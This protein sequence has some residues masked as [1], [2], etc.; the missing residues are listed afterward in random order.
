MVEKEIMTRRV[1]RKKDDERREGDIEEED[2]I[3]G[4]EWR[5]RTYM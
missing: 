4:R 2:D 3:E 5:D 1:H